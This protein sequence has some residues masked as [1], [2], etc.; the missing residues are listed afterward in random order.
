MS[1]CKSSL[2]FQAGCF[3]IVFNYTG[4][5]LTFGRAVESAKSQGVK[6][7]HKIFVLYICLGY[8]FCH[9]LSWDVQLLGCK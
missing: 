9:D 2:S 4:D 6:V 3:V 5:R 1:L 7:M 8:G